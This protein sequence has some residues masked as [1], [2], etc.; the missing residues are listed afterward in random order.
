MGRTVA[1]I[2]QHVYWPGIRPAIRKEIKKRDTCQRTQRSNIQDGKL[3]SKES[4]EIPRNKFCVCIRGSYVIT[5][6]GN[7]IF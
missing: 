2:H 6:K 4:E 3:P 1:M 5:R 7:K